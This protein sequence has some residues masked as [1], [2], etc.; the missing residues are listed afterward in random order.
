MSKS[1]MPVVHVLG[2]VRAPFLPLALVCVA[3]GSALAAHAGQLTASWYD[4]LLIALGALAAHASVN[5]FN[6]VSDYLTGIDRHTQRTPFSGGS[7][8]LPAQPQWLGQ[9]R[10]LAWALLLFVV[11]V[12][13]YF[14]LT[15]S[16]RLLPLGLIGL[17]LVRFYTPWITRRPWLCLAAPGL[18]FGPVMVLGVLL[19]AGGSLQGAAWLSC[20][21]PCLLTSALLLFNQFPDVEADRLGGRHN[22]PIWIGRRASSVVLAGLHALAYGAV[23]LGVWLHW[24]PVV[25]LVALL[26]VPLSVA[27]CHAAWRDAENPAQLTPALGL[28]VFVCLLTPALLAAAWWW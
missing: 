20:A 22:L 5:A 28:N 25:C 15:R 14:C 13:L 21:V 6:E 19:A 23:L 11:L 27:V 10:W 1:L 4:W 9:A 3:L 2:V 7:G 8:T 12:G 24:M 17:A 26:P 16:W 18:G